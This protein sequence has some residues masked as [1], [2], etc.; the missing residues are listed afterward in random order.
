[1][2]IKLEGDDEDLDLVGD[3]S[4]SSSGYS[5]NLPDFGVGGSI[6]SA[7]GG[8]LSGVTTIGA[9]G[10]TPGSFGSTGFLPGSDVGF[11]VP[12]VGSN[13]GNVFTF[14]A[15]GSMAPGGMSLGDLINPWN[16]RTD[17]SQLN[18]NW[19]TWNPST[20]FSTAGSDLTGVTLTGKPF[21]NIPVIGSEPR[22]D[23]GA[24]VQTGSQETAVML[25]PYKVNESTQAPLVLDPNQY[26]NPSVMGGNALLGGV[27]TTATSGVTML[28]PFQVVGTK[29]PSAT[30]TFGGQTTESGQSGIGQE[31]GGATVLPKM[32]VTGDRVTTPTMSSQDMIDLLNKATTA[33]GTQPVTLPPVKAETGTSQVNPLPVTTSVPPV[34]PPPL[35]TVIPPAVTVPPA[36]TPTSTPTGVTPTTTSNQPTITQTGTATPTTTSTSS[37]M[38]ERDLAAELKKTMAALK[39]YQP[40][41]QQMYGDLYKQFMPA[42]IT[43]AEPGLINQYQSDLARLQQRQAGILAPEDIRQSQQAAREAYGARGQ[44]MGPGAVGAEILNREAIRQQREDQARAALQQS[45]G[46]ILNTANIQTGNLFSPIASLM[47]STFNPLGAYPADVYGTNVNAQLARDIAQKN[48]EAAVK[49]AELSGAAQK[50]AGTT[51]AIGNIGS[52]LIPSLISGIGN[53]FCWVARE[54]YGENNPKWLQ[55]REWMFTCAPGWFFNFYLEHGERIAAWLKRHPWAKAPIRIWMDSRIRSLE[56][57]QLVLKEAV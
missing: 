22:S 42:G 16:Q 15:P 52:A 40:Q 45:Y 48:Y 7:P 30:L 6:F 35:S 21:N 57:R 32:T 47:S 23:V 36:T 46:N 31:T 13:I 56:K 28:D 2:A 51:S 20:D 24:N 18:P 19:G 1:M 34:N 38:T 53:I 54:V 33:W 49:S 5:P 50:Q 41:I 10:A 14:G 11:D 4:S 12:G 44:V 3:G 55:F 39:E 29:L 43:A 37:A 27:T 17:I 9:D 8:L 25:D 26:I